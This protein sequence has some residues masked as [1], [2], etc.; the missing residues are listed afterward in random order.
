MTGEGWMAARRH[1][2][3]ASIVTFTQMS[4]QDGRVEG[5]LVIHT[6]LGSH[7]AVRS[8]IQVDALT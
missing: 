7:V 3:L 8:L 1:L 2:I 5:E 6:L 4:V